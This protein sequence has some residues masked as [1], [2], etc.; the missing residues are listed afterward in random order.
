M[1]IVLEGIDGSGKSTLA[2]RLGEE[3]AAR[4]HEVVRTR[5]PTQGIWG[6]KIRSMTRGR[7]NEVTAEEEV[8]WFCADREEH[9]REVVAPALARGAWVVQDRSYFST[10]A[11][12]GAR[13]VDRD[14]L[15][16]RSRVIAPAPD[17]LLVV[18]IPADIAMRRIET[19]RSGGPDDFESEEQLSALRAVFVGFEGAVV[20]DGLASPHVLEAAALQVLTERG[21]LAP[22]PSRAAPRW[23]GR[24]RGSLPY[25]PRT[26]PT[27]ATP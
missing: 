27:S 24:G 11:Y 17:L 23:S 3:I 9:V 8:D 16:S 25:S 6:K 19:Q 4:G 5:E 7:R 22:S 20:L 18:D 21:W 1:L 15:M 12:Q 14:V 2:R 10:V 13:G 26:C